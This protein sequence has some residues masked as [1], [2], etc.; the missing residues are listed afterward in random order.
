MAKEREFS[1]H[2]SKEKGRFARTAK[3]EYSVHHDAVREKP[4]A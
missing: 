3:Q 1:S 4:L 2:A